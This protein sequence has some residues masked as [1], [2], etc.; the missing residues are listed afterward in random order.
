MWVAAEVSKTRAGNASREQNVIAA[1]TDTV[2]LCARRSKRLSLALFGVAASFAGT[3]LVG[4]ETLPWMNQ[5]LAP[6]QRAVLLVSAMTLDQ[7]IQQI[8]MNPGANANL[9]GCGFLASGRHIEGISHLAIPT[10]RMTNGPIG[11]GGGDCSPD[12]VAT[13]VATAL[14]AAASWDR[15]VWSQWGDIVGSETRAN[16]HQIFL[17]PGMNMARAPQN[18]R[19][20]EYLGEDPLLTGTASVAMTRAIQ[21][22]G[23]L[24]SAKHYAANEQETQRQTMNSIIDDRTLHE[25]Y[26]LPFEMVIKDA[27]AASVMCSYPRVNGAYS[28]ESTPLLKDVLREQWGFKGFVMSDRGATKSTVPSIKAG[29]DLEFAKPDWFTPDRV[30]AA[31][32]AN[33]I[34]VADLDMMLQRRF[35]MMFKFGQFDKPLT[36]FAPIDLAD[37]GVKARAMAEQGSVLLK[38]EFRTLPLRATA[39]RSIALIGP[40]TF[41][42]AAKLPATGPG[43]FITV[44][45]SY[46]V[47][48]MQGLRRVLDSLGSTATITYN[49]GKDLNSAIALARA[50][51][52]AI[53]MVG[54]ISLEGVDRQNL[55]LPKI[56]GVD[57]Q[58]LVTAIAAVQPRSVVVLKDGGPILMPWIDHVGAV[59]EVWYPG[60]EDG[61]A[62]ADLL[63]GVANPSGKLPVTFPGAE[64]EAAV[65][66]VAQWPG[67]VVNGV[68]T[69]SYA[70]G[71]KMGYRWYDANKVA[72]QFPF[73]FGLSYTSFTYSGMH[74]SSTSTDG[75]A[76][77]S[78]IFSV[79]NAGTVGGADVAQLYATFPAEY[80]E[81]KRLVGFQ[82]VFLAP[83]EQKQVAIAVDPQTT[84]HPLSYWNTEMKNW[85]LIRG[86]VDFQL[87]RSSQQTE[88]E[89]S[90]TVGP[91]D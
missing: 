29:L 72:P 39:L 50:S 76:P 63:F 42:A 53:I 23:V 21:A 64:R 33:E 62:V 80:G 32:D 28:C 54:D 18:G 20:F 5:G 34:T 35:R 83:G 16:A 75:R 88:K 46:S 15:T 1:R 31:L 66:T 59:L 41:A 56:D 58:S 90:V 91:Q 87:G 9:P 47:T 22:N 69:A 14:S 44:N 13:G 12:R 51:D 11:V 7:K 26:L 65:S 55:D 36:A 82:K 3:Q 70:E 48:P 45:A 25:L 19:N 67:A 61:N 77:L 73:G 38:N 27:E 85:Q 89:F 4:A 30:K 79:Q 86:K 57:Q 84:N 2:A 49:D 40:P 71:L 78:V 81:P 17:A 52:A 74:M 60:Q 8:A 68:L 10:V 24:A 37:H 6:E 43:G